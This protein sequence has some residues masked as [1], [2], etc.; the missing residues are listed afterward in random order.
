MS[1]QD[2]INSASVNGTPQQSARWSVDIEDPGSDLNFSLTSLEMENKES[3]VEV[4]VYACCLC[5]FY[6]FWMNTYFKYRPISETD[7]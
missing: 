3:T 7:I 5:I 4:W 6:L 1:D 2:D